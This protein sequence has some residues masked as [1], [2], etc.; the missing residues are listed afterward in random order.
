MRPAAALA[1]FLCLGICGVAKPE[2]AVPA[3]SPQI[4]VQPPKVDFGSAPQERSLSQVLRVRNLGGE[5]LRIESITTTCGCTVVD[6]GDRVLKPGGET[7][8]KVTLETRRAQGKIA[9]Q[10]LFRSNDPKTPQLAVTLEVT[11]SAP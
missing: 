5:D 9:R 4:D 7:T 6:G 10:V 11:V 3:K 8:V 2:T 1:A